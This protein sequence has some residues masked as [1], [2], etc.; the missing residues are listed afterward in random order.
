MAPTKKSKATKSTE[1]INARLALTVKSG[2]Y[3]LGYKSSLKAM[4]NGKGVCASFPIF[5]G[6]GAWGWE[7]PLS[8]QNTFFSVPLDGLGFFSWLCLV[9]L[10][11]G[12]Q[13]NSCWLLATAL[14]CV[15]LSW[16]ITPCSPR[17]V[18]ITLLET[19]SVLVLLLENSSV[20]GMSLLCI[21]F[22]WKFI[23]VV[24]WLSPTPETRTFLTSLKAML[25]KPIFDGPYLL[26]IFM[27]FLKI[28]G[29]YYECDCQVLEYFI[30]M[31][32]GS[33]SSHKP[34]SWKRAHWHDVWYQQDL[35]QNVRSYEDQKIFRS[36]CHP[37]E[38]CQ[39]LYVLLCKVLTG[40]HLSPKKWI[41]LKVSSSSLRRAYVLSQPLGKISNESWPP[42]AKVN[43]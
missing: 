38:G 29:V 32:Y 8:W 41:S 19:M 14:L 12:G 15:N 11:S 26:S 7:G 39:I 9:V 16:S 40:W 3:T 6:A 34:I 2:K 30:N 18:F 28:I 5:S 17:L 33:R 23:N 13:P 21:W 31:G 35:R 24:S 37:R 43:P 20:L 25:P 36:H 4:T 42:M 10:V 1:S 27:H 22:D